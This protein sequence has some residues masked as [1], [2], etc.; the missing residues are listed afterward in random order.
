MKESDGIV[1]IYSGD[2]VSVIH[3]KGELESADIQ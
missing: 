1:A 2:E 3:L